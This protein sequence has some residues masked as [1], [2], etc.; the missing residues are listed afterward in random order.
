M[1]CSNCCCNVTVCRRDLQLSFTQR[2]REVEQRFSGDQESAEKCF[3]AQLLKL[4]QHYQSEL[5]T[6][7][8]SHKE[9]KLLLDAQLQEAL[10]NAEERGRRTEEAVERERERLNGQWMEEVQQQESRHRQEVQELLVK[11]Q[12]LQAEMD[13]LGGASQTAQLELSRQL[14]ELHARLQESLEAKDELLAQSQRG[15]AEAELLLRQSAEE[16]EELLSACAELEAQNTEMVSLRERR[17]E[18]RED[19][20]G[21]RDA[22]KTKVEELEV[23]L[24][25]AAADF[26][27]E[28]K[29]LQEHVSI[30]EGRLRDSPGSHG[31]DLPVPEDEGVESEKGDGWIYEADMLSEGKQEVEGDS[32]S[33]RCSAE[34]TSCKGLDLD[35]PDPD[36]NNS[37]NMEAHSEAFLSQWPCEQV[38]AFRAPEGSDASKGVENKGDLESC[39]TKSKPQDVPAWLGGNLP[40]D[41]EGNH[42]IAGDP[43]VPEEAGDPDTPSPLDGQVSHGR[44]EPAAPW[45]FDLTARLNPESSHVDPEVP[46]EGADCLGLRPQVRRDSAAE[47]NVLLLEKISLLQQKTEILESLLNHNGE[48]IKTG[49]RALEENYGL[50][51]RTLLLLEHVRELQLKASKAAELQSRYQVCLC[52]NAWLKHHNGQLEKRVQ[53]LERGAAGRRGFQNPSKASLLVEIGTLRDDNRKFSE[54]LGE[55]ERQREI[56]S[57][58]PAV[59]A[60]LG[61]PGP[62]EVERQP[63]AELQG[64]CTELEKENFGLREAIWAMRGESQTLHENTQAQR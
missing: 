25:Q 6:L 43:S 20:V 1:F 10:Q 40:Q 8:H 32:A 34:S 9:Q 27:L 14:N 62:A 53:R 12:Q 33:D 44:Q 29:E 41:E 37:M 50:K 42:E 21:E 30:L 58:A 4:E 64:C 23:L 5:E 49:N 31:E 46:A 51:V 15:A 17:V 38:S 24:Q 3:Q 47:E 57:A 56:L 13:E 45:N 61:A 7:S 48:K 16:R 36:E 26:Y 18:E 63:A 54:L 39:E 11:N 59:E 2:L 28:R 60:L 55:L 35:S 22:L 19:L 52:E